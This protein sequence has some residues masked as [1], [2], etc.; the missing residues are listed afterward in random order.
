MVDENT[1][2]KEIENALI[3]LVK[4]CLNKDSMGFKAPLKKIH[5]G[6]KTI[7]E[8]E[9]KF[10]QYEFDEDTKEF[11]NIFENEVTDSKNE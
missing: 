2:N 8:I 3:V 6:K 9:F 11:I 4:E 10:N 7:F 5:N 1:K